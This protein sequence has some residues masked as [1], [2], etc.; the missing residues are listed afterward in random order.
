[1]AE[2]VRLIVPAA[3]GGMPAVAADAQVGANVQMAVRRLCSYAR[4]ASVLA[5]KNG[6]FGLREVGEMVTRLAPI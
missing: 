4:H 2:R 6:R 1:V 3:Q 5:D